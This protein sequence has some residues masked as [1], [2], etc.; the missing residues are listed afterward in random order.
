LATGGT[1]SYGITATGYGSGLGIYAIGGATGG[2]V[3]FKSGGGDNS[4][5]TTWGTGTGNGFY[6]Y[7]SGSGDGMK[8][9]STTGD[10]FHSQGNRDF[11]IGILGTGYIEGQIRGVDTLNSSVVLP[12]TDP[13][14]NRYAVMPEGWS[15][16][17][18][19]A[20]QGSAGSSG[21]T[22]A[23][24]DT[25]LSLYRSGGF[26]GNLRLNG[27]LQ[28]SRFLDSAANGAGG[29]FKV[30]N[31]TG[32]GAIFDGSTS[33]NDVI[34]YLAGPVGSVASLG[35]VSAD[36]VSVSGSPAT[37]DN[38]ELI[39]DGVVGT[40]GSAS[41][42]QVTITGS[43]GPFGSLYV[44]NSTGP[45]AYFV[46]SGSG[47][48]MYSGLKAWSNHG[49][50]AEFG[51]LDTSSISAPIISGTIDSVRSLGSG[52]S[53]GM[54]LD[55]FVDYVNTHPDVFGCV[56][57]ATPPAY[58]VLITV[59][60]TSSVGDP[61]LQGVTVTVVNSGGV[62]I[63]T[64]VTNSSGV[65]QATLNAGTYTLKI[66]RPGY[67]F[68]STVITVSGD[69]ST[70]FVG[71][72]TVGQYKCRVWGMVK[73]LGGAAQY[74]AVRV[75]LPIATKNTC[76]TTAVFGRDTTIMTN[77]LGLFEIELPFSSCFENAKYVFSIPNLPSLKPHQIL[78]PDSTTYRIVW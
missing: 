34:G 73:G 59:Q 22:S 38:L 76:D 39:Y 19:I 3:L 63:Q 21:W 36:V 7:T 61:V 75:A 2:G 44:N 26:T 15:A 40:T 23:K 18:S 11:V 45:G 57:G 17:D 25:A 33:T 12:T 68:D 49:Y 46:A 48:Q 58:T 50:G 71:R 78:V 9:V 54:T 77:S 67:V 13:Y 5:L 24:V 51:S 35:T 66:F 10:G 30:Y 74:V 65:A 55:D 31:S 6:G 8:L 60:D 4:G 72:N 37:A 43:N 20:Y 16:D 64:P 41:F 27:T 1:T 28:I 42:S 29:S 62:A 69:M 70:T 56:S 47:S 52:G 53:G 32:S 14:G